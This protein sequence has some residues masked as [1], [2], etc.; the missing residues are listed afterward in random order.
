MPDLR[1]FEPTRPEPADRG[2]R[3]L[4]TTVLAV[5][6]LAA[7]ATAQDPLIVAPQAYQ[8]QFENERVKVVRVHY[9]PLE[10]LPVHDHPRGL[11]IFVYLN[12]GGLVRFQHVEGVSGDY[13]ARRPPTQSRAYRLAWRADENHEVENLSDAPSDFL[14]VHLLTEIVDEKTFRGRFYSDPALSKQGGNQRKAEFDDAHVRITRMF[15]AA[16]GECDPLESSEHPA[17]VVALAPF[18]IADAGGAADASPPGL[19]P[20]DT[21]WLEPGSTW[22]LSNPGDSSSELLLIELKQAPSP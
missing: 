2:I 5:A 21:R 18:R 3:V 8:L 15:C 9:E 14:Q 7:P 19:E 12:D 20:G 6:A 16:G 4:L 13:V 1:A 22:R 11:A 10:K 17:L